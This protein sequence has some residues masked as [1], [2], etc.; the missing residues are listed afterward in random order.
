[1]DQ[2]TVAS[3]I[4]LLGRRNIAGYEF[5]GIEGDSVKVRKQC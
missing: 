5:T 1:M 3:E 2:L 4:R